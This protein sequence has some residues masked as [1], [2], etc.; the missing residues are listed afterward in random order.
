V[1]DVSRVRRFNRR[2]TEILG[3][4]G[5]GLLATDLSLTEARVIFELAHGE[6]TERL[7]LRRRL[8]I[9]D[10]FLTRVLRGLE[11]NGLVAVSPSTVDGRRRDLVLTT[12]GRAAFAELD[13]RSDEQVA[14]LLAP[15]STDQRRLLGDSMTVIT[16]LVDPPGGDPTVVIRDLAN[17]DLGWVIERHGEIYADEYGWSIE[18]EGLVARIVADFWATRRPARERAWIAEVD[19]VRAG[20][21]FCVERDPDCAQLRILLVEPWAR[22][23][24]IGA[25]LVDDCIA[26]ARRAGYPRIVLWTNDV[27][28]SARRIYEAAGFRLVDEEPHHSF[29]DDLVGQNWE[30]ELGRTRRRTGRR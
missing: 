15:L 26:F 20:C 17:G 11:A 7:E 3:L 14:A 22:G 13:G 27:L 12:R 19:G 30:L 16:K 18:F 29:G 4:L 5:Q 6:R 2:W 10:S 25:R 1:D 21:V 28:V 8:G 9:D 23:L 24:G